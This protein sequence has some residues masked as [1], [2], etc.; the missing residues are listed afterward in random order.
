[1]IFGLIGAALGLLVGG[2]IGSGINTAMNGNK[3]QYTPGKVK[4]VENGKPVHTFGASCANKDKSQVIVCA[5]AVTDAEGKYTPG[6]NR[7]CASD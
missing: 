2:G 4:L 7:R 6:E 3:Q 5:E 1:M